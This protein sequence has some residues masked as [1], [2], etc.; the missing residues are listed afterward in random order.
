MDT[1][2]DWPDLSARPDAAA[3]VALAA[4][5]LRRL[6]GN[7]PVGTQELLDVSDGLLSLTPPVG[8]EHA[9]TMRSIA[10]A[11]LIAAICP[12][13]DA[14]HVHVTYDALSNEGLHQW[15]LLDEEHH[16]LAEDLPT[17]DLIHAIVSDV[18]L[19]HGNPAM[20]VLWAERTATTGPEVAA[21][22][23]ISNILQR[24]LPSD[25][26]ADLR[27]M[28]T[29]LGAA[30]L[31]A[32]D[33]SAVLDYATGASPNAPTDTHLST[34]GQ[35]MVARYV[36]TAEEHDILTAIEFAAAIVARDLTAA[37][38]HI[39]EVA[40]SG[41][42]SAGANAGVTVTVQV[43]WRDGV[44]EQDMAVDPAQ[45]IDLFVKHVVTSKEVGEYLV[46]NGHQVSVD[47]D[48]LVER[49]GARP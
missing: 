1:L 30:P 14:L 37:C 23:S 43:L 44:G 48:A 21:G 27:A 34:A 15:A 42:P 4:D 9:S 20:S 25:P 8:V 22:I 11:R 29:G 45:L 19:A 31:G 26:D 24:T 10:A 35:H 2:S 49:Y 33:I 13:A 46:T 32:T 41:A 18:V 5:L 12:T 7:T 28:L 6:G 47:V 39:A 38:P 36:D 40:F 17:R 3:P 16:P